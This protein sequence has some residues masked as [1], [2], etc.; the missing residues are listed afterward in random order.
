MHNACLL[1]DQ[2]VPCAFPAKVF[3]SPKDMLSLTPPTWFFVIHVASK[4]KKPE[5]TTDV[6][7][8]S[9]KKKKRNKEQKPKPNNHTMTIV[10]SGS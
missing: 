4:I 5:P 7:A 3:V 1:W 2:A 10:G 6:A 9:G 8:G